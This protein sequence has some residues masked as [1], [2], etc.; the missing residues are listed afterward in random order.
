MNGKSDTRA[1]A[2]AP[3]DEGTDRPPLPRTLEAVAIDGPAGSGKST[4]ARAVA[5]A[6]G[7]L[8]VDTG[9]MYR[10]I[11]L[12]ATR[13]GVD[14]E[15]PEAMGQVAA[16]TRL[17]F[18]ATGTRILMDGEDVSE[19]IRT[20]EITARTR[21]AARA[22]T[23]RAELLR[24]QR[25][26][27][28]ERPAVMEGRDITTVVLRDA[29]W[30]FFVTARPEV[31]ADRRLADFAAKGHEVDRGALLRE[32][33]DRDASDFEVGPMRDAWARAQAPGG[34]IVFVDTSDMSPEEVIA[35]L[36]GTVRAEP[37]ADA[38]R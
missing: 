14:L 18:D 28:E 34:G 25:A 37:E 29:K 38:S 35:Y 24:R 31:R 23:V 1:Q 27:A 11:A 16:A 19:A 9:A 10:A 6:L 5:D 7:F 26:L 13:T 36:V 2:D 15:S 20:P 8:Y 33:E 4:I 3:R 30:K 12:K 17:D 22:P 32:I 21:F